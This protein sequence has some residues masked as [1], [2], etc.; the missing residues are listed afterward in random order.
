VRTGV[1]SA[2][3][4]GAQQPT[5][6]PG[7]PLPSA[8]GVQGGCILE[9]F[10]TFGQ[11]TFEPAEHGSLTLA[12]NEGNLWDLEP[13]FRREQNHLGPPPQPEC[14]DDAVQSVTLCTLRWRQ[15]WFVDRSYPIRIPSFV[16]TFVRVLRPTVTGLCLHLGATQGTTHQ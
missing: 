14:L 16:E 4:G 8:K 1:L 9:P 12:G 11:L 10:N 7:T 5:A 15:R 13:L 2:A 6:R 3:V